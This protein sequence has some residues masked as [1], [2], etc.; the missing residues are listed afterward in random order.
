MTR[1][2]RAGSPV[3]WRRLLVAGAVYTAVMVATTLLGWE[4]DPLALALVVA[5]GV[6]VVGLL[7]LAAGDP[8]ARG[9]VRWGVHR[10]GGSGLT[11]RD[12]QF[13]AHLRVLE[14]HLTARTPDGAVR[15]R[16]RTVADRR[17]VQHHGFRSDDERARPLLGPELARDL[18]GPP[19]RLSLEE[20]EQHVSRIEAL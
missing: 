14:S 20:L 5:L 4:P 9:A 6:G 17:L 15:D 10:A 7:V 2:T 1:R 12:T 8:T 11:G 16:L 19:R 13:L 18:A 3:P